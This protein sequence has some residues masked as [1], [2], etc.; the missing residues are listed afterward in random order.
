[1]RL[2]SIEGKNYRSYENFY[3]D[4]T[5]LY[6][7]LIIACD[8]NGNYEESNA[9]GKSNLCKSIGWC[10][11]G[12][13]GSDKID[14][15]VKY[16][17]VSNYV[18][19]I[20]EHDNKICSI[21]RTRNKTLKQ[22][23]LDFEINGEPS[24]GKSVTETD[25]KIQEFLKLDYKTYVN[26]VFIRQNDLYSLANPEKAKDANDIF[27]K[28]INLSEYNKLEKETDS[29]IKEEEKELSN[30]NSFIEI[31][32]GY[33]LKISSAENLLIEEEKNIVVYSNKLDELEKESS[34]LNEK[35]KEL[36]SIKIKN[37]AYSNR[38]SDIKKDLEIKK[39]LLE[40]EKLKGLKLAEQ[41]KNNIATLEE[42]INKENDIKKNID[43]FNN[44]IKESLLHE[45]KYIDIKETIDKLTKEISILE[46]ELN[47]NKANKISLDSK[48]VD[49]KNELLTKN[50]NLNNIS[51]KSGEKC[52]YCMSDVTDKNI[53]LII[54]TR[55]EEIYKSELYIKEQQIL[56]SEKEKEIKI[57]EDK[58]NLNKIN[59]KNKEKDLFDSKSKIIAA[60]EKLE[61]YKFFDQQISD[62]ENYKKQLIEEKEAQNLKFVKDNFERLKLEIGSLNKEL[63]EIDSNDINNIKEI[64]ISL[65][66]LYDKK[67]NI[68]NELKSIN[69]SKYRSISNID[70]FKENI[71]NWKKILDDYNT[72]LIKQNE[73]NKNILCLEQ[74][75]FAFSSKG[76]RLKLIEDSI[77]ELENESN[78]IL[79]KMSNNN[80]NFRFI[81][82]KERTDGTEKAVFEIEVIEKMPYGNVTTSY[83]QLSGGQQLRVSFVIR[84]ALSKLLLGRTNSK[85]EFLIIDEAISPLDG[86]GIVTF[87]QTINDLQDEFKNILV[88]THRNDVKNMFDQIITVTK[89]QFGSKILSE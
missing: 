24:N 33:D 5:G 78:K 84:V 1:M 12:E 82:S 59:L 2:L 20:F 40:E 55:K 71:K 38:V 32:K 16:D 29:R 14:Q 43:N 48:I 64:E 74:I 21:T 77:R 52:K 49:L 63:L 23:Q 3:I 15:S 9:R 30:L 47:K 27:E 41:R 18:K 37:E 19:L 8:E 28:V 70:N 66:T 67:K 75:K 68:D 62:I 87:M 73:T 6:K 56:V 88:I 7:T 69:Q 51:V 10:I 44:K 22:S 11:F 86:S 25:K 61:K 72:A 76:I 39:G 79:K 53:D 36:E 46:I 58:Y 26:S 31:N 81:T 83:N 57:I 80:L 89:D 60:T 45:Q 35:I 42:K 4:F 13:D 50:K 85:L 54:N 65:V 34:Q 17:A